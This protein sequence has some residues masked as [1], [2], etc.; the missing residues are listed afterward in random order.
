MYFREAGKRVFNI[1]FGEKVVIQDL[2]IVANVGPFA[3]ND[4]YIEFEFKEDQI[5]H[6]EEVCP[7]ALKAR[8]Q[9]LIVTLEKTDKDLPIISG[10]VLYQG[11]LEG[12]YKFIY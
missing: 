12:I 6:S 7:K 11:G 5:F 9:K 8:G 3:A 4:E 2:D 10:L 1:K